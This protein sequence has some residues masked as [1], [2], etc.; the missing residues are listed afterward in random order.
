MDRKDITDKG[1]SI[2]QMRETQ[3][4]RMDRTGVGTFLS[5]VEKEEENGRAETIFT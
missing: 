3:A 4:S 2:S 1:T 5:E